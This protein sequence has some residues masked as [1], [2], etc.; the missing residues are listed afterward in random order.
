MRVLRI[1]HH[2]H[3]HYTDSGWTNAGYGGSWLTKVARGLFYQ[4]TTHNLVDLYE[5][6][7]CSTD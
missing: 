6:R 3:Y 7:V 1:T 2:I 5:S 4:D